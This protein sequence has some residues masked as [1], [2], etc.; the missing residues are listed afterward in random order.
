MLKIRLIAAAAALLLTALTL[1]VM[2]W[3][4]RVFTQWYHHLTPSQLQ[5]FNLSQAVL[6]LA[7]AAVSFWW[8]K[9]KKNQQQPK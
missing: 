8:V 5:A 7:V 1:P 6:G 2:L 3:I 4:Y 9:R